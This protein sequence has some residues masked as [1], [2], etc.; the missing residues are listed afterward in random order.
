MVNTSIFSESQLEAFNAVKNKENVFI[1]GSSGNGKSFLIKQLNAYFGD[2]LVKTS[3]TGIS[4]FNINGITIHSFLNLGIGKYEVRESV[5]FMKR[6]IKDYIKTKLKVLVVDEISM[7]NAEIFQKMDLILQCIKGN[8]RFMGGITFVASG[9]FFQLETIDGTLIFESELWKNNMKVVELSKNFRQKDDPGFLDMLMRIRV[10]EETDTD[11]VVLTQKLVNPEEIKDNLFVIYPV[12]SKVKLHNEKMYKKLAGFA[13]KTYKTV[14]SGNKKI[15]DDLKKQFMAR[16]SD[17]LKLKKN[18]RVM[19][20]RNISIQEGLVNGALGT[21]VDFV[22]GGLPFVK[23]DHLDYPV[24]VDSVKWETNVGMEKGSATQIP[25]V[26]AY[27]SSI[28]KVQGLTLTSAY[29]DLGSCFCNHQVYVALSRVKS[30]DGLKLL[31]FDPK[32]I[33]INEKVKNYYESLKK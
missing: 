27:A 11:S 22:N 26:V 12:N 20:L 28:H 32:K 2:A 15:S 21:I 8:S 29:L 16:D 5:K 1:T 23:F 7:L 33:K 31:S 14:Y 19:L 17:V 13:E 25:L 6:E 30:I 24:V 10:N 18:C 3:S 9:D 4:A